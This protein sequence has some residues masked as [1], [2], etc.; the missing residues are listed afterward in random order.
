MLNQVRVKRLREA[1]GLVLLLNS[2]HTQ[3]ELWLKLHICFKK[4]VL[5][6]NKD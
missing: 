2:G 6:A 5:L 4:C 3:V 1:V